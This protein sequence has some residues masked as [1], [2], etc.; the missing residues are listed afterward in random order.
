MGQPRRSAA[1]TV[2]ACMRPLDPASP[3]PQTPVH[4]SAK[5]VRRQKVRMETGAD[6]RLAIQHQSLRKACRRQKNGRRTVPPRDEVIARDV[7]EYCILAESFVTTEP[8]LTWAGSPLPGDGALR[9]QGQG[10]L[11]ATLNTPEYSRP[12]AP[13]RQGPAEWG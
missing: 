12:R 1:C 3:S 2:K 13:H 7:L 4:T 10:T 9:E 11:A 5:E 8:C 6:P